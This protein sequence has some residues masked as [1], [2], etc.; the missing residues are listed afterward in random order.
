MRAIHSRLIS[1]S[2]R[3]S[4][5]AVPRD[6][7]SSSEVPA[8]LRQT[9][10][11]QFRGEDGLHLCSTWNCVSR[12][13]RRG[14]TVIHK[15]GRGRRSY[16]TLNIHREI[17]DQFPQNV[18]GYAGSHRHP[19]CEQFAETAESAECVDDER[20]SHRSG[21]PHLSGKPCRLFH[22]MP[23]DSSA[24]SFRLPVLWCASGVN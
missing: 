12:H 20:W 18:Q 5:L 7:E 24:S 17:V 3:P 16:D 21:W 15:E 6:N 19:E 23:C 8:Q 13:N 22:R 10:L 9:L 2:N 4:S 1:V 14:R 11:P